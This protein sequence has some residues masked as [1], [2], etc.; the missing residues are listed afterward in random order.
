VFDGNGSSSGKT[1]P[2]EAPEKA[3]TR[4]EAVTQLTRSDTPMTL[5]PSTIT[6]TST[7]ALTQHRSAQILAISKNTC[8]HDCECSCHRTSIKKNSERTIRGSIATVAGPTAPLD[9][10]NQCSVP[11]C[12]TTKQRPHQRSYSLPLRNL[13]RALTVLIL[14]QGLKF[15]L[16]LRIPT[17][18]PEYSELYT[19]T[20]EG[21]LE[22]L[23]RFFRAHPAATNIASVTRPDGW[24]PLHVSTS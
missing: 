16:Y 15:R 19:Y 2:V 3:G 6:F 17:Y 22:N 12:E 23:K 21:D 7:T 18:V 14:W 9:V 24:T 11:E 5:R 20:R 13:H 4:N 8:T 10:N 1:V